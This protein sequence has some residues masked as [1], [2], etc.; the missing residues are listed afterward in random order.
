MIDIET[1][2]NIILGV[3]FL[4]ILNPRIAFAILAVTFALH[5]WSVY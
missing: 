4:G 5:H 3:L 1:Y 2:R